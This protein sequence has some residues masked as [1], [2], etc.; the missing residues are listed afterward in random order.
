M[1]NDMT[2]TEPTTDAAAI[3]LAREC[4]YRFLAAALSDPLGE[5]WAFLSDLASQRLAA[6]AAELIREEA[7]ASA[8][9]LGFGELPADVLDLTAVVSALAVARDE[10][11]TE[12]DRVFGLV[13]SRECPPF[14]TEY[15]ST[16][17]PFFRA[18]QTADVAGFYRA[19]GLEPS[20]RAPERP[21]HIAL[22]LEFVALLLAKKR[23]ATNTEQVVVCT[24]AEAAF[25][26]DHLA[27]WVPSF[28]TGLRR[29][30]AGGLYARVGQVLAAFLPVERERFRVAAPR[31]PLQAALIEQPEEQAGCASCAS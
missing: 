2:A 21:D 20:R 3:D 31:M 13:P 5:Q 22:E 14:E 24:E 30:G 6:D 27:W 11:S 10:L 12:Y 9:V 4:V 8:V 19:F 28:A 17:E 23:L 1:G 26:R 25:F 15:H 29:K 18:Q 16:T 7:G